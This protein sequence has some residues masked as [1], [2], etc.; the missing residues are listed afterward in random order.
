[1]SASIISTPR[2]ASIRRCSVRIGIEIAEFKGGAQVGITSPIVLDLNGNGV[3]LVNNRNTDVSFDWDSDGRRNQTGWIGRDDGFLVFDR[4]GDG[5]V[6]DGGELSFTADKPGAKSDL[7]GLRAFD[8]NGD[9]Q[10]SS[11]D[12]KFS[13][14]RVWRDA[15]GN[16]R[17]ERSE[18]MSLQ[19]AGVA[20]INL[21]GEA[22]NRSWNWGDNM[23]IN[24]GSYTRTDGTTAAFGDVALNYDVSPRRAARSFLVHERVP[25]RAGGVPYVDRAAMQLGEAMAGFVD[26]RGLGD[27]R[28]DEAVIAQQ[29]LFLP[30][31]RIM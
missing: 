7:D 22:V 26:G 8:S 10:F 1:M 16:G 21:A 23:T 12:E 2:S 30:V 31:P 15:N 17:S 11:D 29:E 24:N 25:H 19:D 20:A 27:L 28:F 9:G 13:S 14:F 6:S 4:D 5:K 3:T 18:M